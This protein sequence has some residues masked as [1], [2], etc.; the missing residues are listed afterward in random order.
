M[1]T[2]LDGAN[3]FLYFTGKNSGV[4]IPSIYNFPSNNGYA[5]SIWVR[6]DSFQSPFDT[7][8]NSYQP[9]IFSFMT[10]SI[11][12]KI[13][14]EGIE[15]YIDKSRHLCLRIKCN[16]N[17]E[18][19]VSKSILS[20]RWKEN[21]WYHIVLTHD[22]G[23][24]K[25][26][27][28]SPEYQS[29]YIYVNG[30]IDFEISKKIY[31]SFK[32][33]FRSSFLG[34]S[35][36]I[37]TAINGE[38]GP[39]Y[40]FNE[41]LST[42]DISLLYLLGHS[43]AFSFDYSTII[44]YL[45]VLE[46]RHINKDEHFNIWKNKVASGYLTS[47]IFLAYTAKARNS[48]DHLL[49]LDTTPF[50]DEGLRRNAYALRGTAQ[51]VTNKLTD[52]LG[53][54]GGIS[55]LF[56][57]FLQLDHPQIIISNPL[58]E[59]LI[60]WMSA[61]NTI[62]DKDYNFEYSYD[63]DGS[64]LSVLLQL[65]IS[66]LQKSSVTKLRQ[67]RQE[68]DINLI[69]FYL[70]QCSSSHLT[71]SVISKFDDLLAGLLLK[72]VNSNVLNE[73]LSLSTTSIM[74][75]QTFWKFI[76]N[77]ELF[78]YVSNEVRLLWLNTFSRYIHVFPELLVKDNGFQLFLN[79]LARCFWYIE[80]YDDQQDKEEHQEQEEQEEKNK[81]KKS[82]KKNEIWRRRNEEEYHHHHQQQQQQQS[83]EYRLGVNQIFSHPITGIKL[84]ERPNNQQ[85]KQMRSK[86]LSLVPHTFTTITKKE[87]YFITSYHFNY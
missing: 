51:C 60:K 50:I 68:M 41:N 21:E 66:I 4:S 2:S 85:I 81:E 1:T 62:I 57:L 43:Y 63:Y 17:S 79:N 69:S 75:R 23:I 47:I 36:I 5:I 15:L 25:N 82:K 38:I 86:L 13:P 10:N 67:I 61:S 20:R 35:S 55:T 73:K 83:K 40:M 26:T 18:A 44:A 59:K 74:F 11:D 49:L 84:G 77:F 6:I 16:S 64:Y 48:K 22:N 58:D 71:S 72:T 34:T 70:C 78:I 54:L 31:P 33:P 3:N 56:P 80:D 29:L 19:S 65:I 53:S 24:K 27:F 46:S 42:N 30:N 9:R 52:V 14:Q 39:F 28:S 45:E 37:N 76:G 8:K 87:I 12:H 32:N 7:N